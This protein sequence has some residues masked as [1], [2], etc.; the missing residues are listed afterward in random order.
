MGLVTTAKCDQQRYILRGDRAQPTKVSYQSQT[1]LMKI[2]G[3]WL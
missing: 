3:L 2:A 1:L